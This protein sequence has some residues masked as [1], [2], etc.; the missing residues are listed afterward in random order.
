M[1]R[2]LEYNNSVHIQFGCLKAAHCNMLRLT[3]EI[4]YKGLVP[5]PVSVS[6]TDCR[7][8]WTWDCGRLCCD[9]GTG[10]NTLP[11]FVQE[12]GQ[13][14]FHRRKVPQVHAA[15]GHKPAQQLQLDDS[16]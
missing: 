10:A 8:V 13:L 5:V 1:R 9:V 3:A 16:P 14:S 15:V 7:L 12:R 6:S 2:W 11:V 4:Y